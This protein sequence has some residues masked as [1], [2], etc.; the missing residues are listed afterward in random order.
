MSNSE[1]KA[2]LDNAI[3]VTENAEYEIKRLIEREEAS[4]ESGLKVGVKGGGCSGLMYTIDFA[5]GPEKGE[6]VFEDKGI[7]IFV[8][9]KSFLYLQGTV[10]DFSG[11]LNGKGFE[12]TNPNASKTCGCGMSFGV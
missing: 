11:G 6:R 8:D 2:V 5:K 3:R 12:F 4:S 10:L 9:L 7:K 1:E